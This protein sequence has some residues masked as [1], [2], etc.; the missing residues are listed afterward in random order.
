MYDLG[1][2]CFRVENENRDEWSEKQ[3]S[4]GKIKKLTSYKAA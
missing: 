3:T 4:S 2:D 1:R